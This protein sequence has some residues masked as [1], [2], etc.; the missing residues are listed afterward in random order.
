[1]AHRARDIGLAALLALAL[2]ASGLL[3]IFTPMPLLYLSVVRGRPDGLM[4]SAAALAAAAAA[5]ALVLFGFG[6]Q[7]QSGAVP[8]PIPAIG[9]LGF[10]TP[11]SVLALGIGYFA[12]FVAVA[13]ALSE[14]IHRR[15]SLAKLGYV[16]LAVA[17]AIFLVVAFCAELLGTSS[18]AGGLR[19]YLDGM[20]GE[21]VKVNHAAG[22]EGG[23][24]SFIRDHAGEI[25]SFMMGIV[26][27]LIIVFSLLTVALNLLV[28][29]RLI[30]SHHAFAH[31]HNVARF[32]LPDWVVW[33]V[34]AGGIAFFADRY[35]VRAGWLGIASINA[36]ICLGA[37]YF[38][39]G[40]A[41]VVY[42]LQGVRMPIVRALA[43]VAIVIFFQT[44]GMIIIAIGL[45]DVWADFRLRSWR[46]RHY[47]T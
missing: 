18:L 47:H 4:A 34:V 2:Y 7:V 9:L 26:P 31:L 22:R 45:A 21:I 30:R 38:F 35:I 5:C 40:M 13:L 25:S 37:I 16:S 11:A 3:V 19:G 15:W 12:F 1:M 17:L 10:L 14:G 32:R 27:S 33:A 43:Y 8:V 42:F 44:I 36:L 41:V 29:R 28:G 23:D 39:Q 20:V 46:T 6:A 24:I